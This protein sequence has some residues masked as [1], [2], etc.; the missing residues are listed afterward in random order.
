MLKFWRAK[1]ASLRFTLTLSV[2]V[3]DIVCTTEPSPLPEPSGLSFVTLTPTEVSASLAGNPDK[4]SCESVPVFSTIS[5]LA[6]K[7]EKFTVPSAFSTGVPLSNTDLA[8]LTNPPISPS[9][10]T[11]IILKIAS[12]CKVFFASVAMIYASLK[13][14]L[15][16][17]LSQ[18]PRSRLS[19]CRTLW[20][21]HYPVSSRFPHR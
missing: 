9:D 13:V 7:P 19:S 16:S 6:S 5:V 14:V 20:E 17:F 11:S 8:P 15:L 1:P 3:L 12:D 10:S 2:V 18:L 4:Y 21:R